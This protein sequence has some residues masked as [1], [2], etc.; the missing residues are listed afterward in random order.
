MSVALT[1]A[2]LGASVLIKRSEAFCLSQ[3]WS[4]SVFGFPSDVFSVF[5]IAQ[6]QYWTESPHSLYDVDPLV[7]ISNLL[8]AP[9]RLTP[10]RVCKFPPAFLPGEECQ[11]KSGAILNQ[12][13][14]AWNVCS[15]TLTVVGIVAPGEVLFI[16]LFHLNHTCMREE[17]G[18]GCRS[19]EEGGGSVL[20]LVELPGKEC[21]PMLI[22]YPNIASLTSLTSEILTWSC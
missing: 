9:R 12:F 6:V 22:P 7:L 5:K 19:E 18:V 11:R 13:R 20:L 2:A 14:N 15:W 17:A 16:Y 10:G 3:R 8:A 4:D 21:A 1:A